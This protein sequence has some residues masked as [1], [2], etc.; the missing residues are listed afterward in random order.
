MPFQGVI[1][2]DCD[3]HV[4]VRSRNN[5]EMPRTFALLGVVQSVT[6]TD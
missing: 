4:W 3:A 6:N 5:N 2:P 1:P